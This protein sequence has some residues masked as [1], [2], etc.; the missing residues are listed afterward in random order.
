[1]VIDKVDLVADLAPVVLKKQRRLELT[2]KDRAVAELKKLW[3][4]G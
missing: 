3:I 4:E 2:R 1:M